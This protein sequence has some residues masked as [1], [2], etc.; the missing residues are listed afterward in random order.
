M[1]VAGRADVSNRVAANAAAD[2]AAGRCGDAAAG[3]VGRPR[4]SREPRRFDL[5]YFP[6]GAGQFV[7]YRD[8]QLGATLRSDE[9]KARD[10]DGHVFEIQLHLAAFAALKHGGGH[11]TYVVSRNLR[12]S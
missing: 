11:K 7:G 1:Q 8:L 9:A 2:A 3:A 5:N 4:G 10:L 12:C 6:N